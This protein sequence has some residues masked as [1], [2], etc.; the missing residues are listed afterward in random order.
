[1][2]KIQAANEEMSMMELADLLQKILLQAVPRGSKVSDTV[3]VNCNFDE[4]ESIL[5]YRIGF[6]KYDLKLTKSEFG[7][8]KG[9]DD[10]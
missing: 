8:V 6:I 3:N 1:M 4:K 7:V 5:S 2:M 10:D 9:E